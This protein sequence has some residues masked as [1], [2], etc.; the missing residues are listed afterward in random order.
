[1]RPI[2]RTAASGA[3]GAPTKGS[4]GTTHLPKTPTGQHQRSKT[5]SRGTEGRSVS[6]SRGRAMTRQVPSPHKSWGPRNPQPTPAQDPRATA[7]ET[8]TQE[9][10]APVRTSHLQR[11]PQADSPAES[12][13]RE[14]P[15][16]SLN[17]LHRRQA[18]EP[19]R[20][21]VRSPSTP[22]HRGAVGA[23]GGGRTSPSQHRWRRHLGPK[24]PRVGS[25]AKEEGRDPRRGQPTPDSRVILPGK[26]GN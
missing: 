24:R 1:M 11:T 17:A 18:G 14:G 20:L 5:L 22:G 9:L 26:L 7:E 21:V 16:S 23:G 8:C 6:V 2:C 13:Q 10:T 4:R 25:R 3:V 12:T 19:L 15:L